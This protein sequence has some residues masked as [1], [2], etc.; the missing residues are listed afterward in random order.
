MRMP[1][2]CGRPIGK[3]LRLEP[4]TNARRWVPLSASGK[5][6][7]LFGSLQSL[8]FRLIAGVQAI[9]ALVWRRNSLAEDVP[10]YGHVSIRPWYWSPRSP[11]SGCRVP[12][13]PALHGMEN[14]KVVPGPPSFGS[15]QRRP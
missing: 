12:A 5:L 15:A 6:L 1:S 8:G 13:P 10:A 9:T 4:L 11:H 14:E 7:T 2:L 3:D